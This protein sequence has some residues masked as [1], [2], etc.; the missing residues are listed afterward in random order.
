MAFV[1]LIL[2]LVALLCFVVAAFGG[3]LGRVAPV[4]LGLAFWVLALLIGG[5][6]VALAH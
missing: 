3:S 1:A 2:M 4:P 6:A 5:G